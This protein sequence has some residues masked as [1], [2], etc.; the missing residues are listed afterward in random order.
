MK[1]SVRTEDLTRIFKGEEGDI[2]A[3]DNVSLSVLP[4]EIFGLLGPNGAGKTTLI[5]ILSTLL[6]PTSGKAFVDG[7][8]VVRETQ[9][10]KEVINLASGGETPG[11]GMLTVKENLWFF[12]QLYGLSNELSKTRIEQLTETV[13]LN[14]KINERM[15]RLSSGMKQRLNIARCL[16]NDPKILFLDEPT[17]GLDVMVA[18]EIRQYIEKLVKERPDKTILLTTHYMAEADQMCNRVA[19]IDRGRVLVVG[20]P[21]KLKA[22]FSKEVNLLVQTSFIGNKADQL[23]KVKG[24]K[25]LSTSHSPETNMTTLKLVLEEEGAVPDVMSTLKEMNAKLHFMQKAETTLETVF[26]SLVGRG[27]E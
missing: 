7:H 24:V 21:E 6:L 16:I 22:I 20:A 12:S 4:G 1:E 25:G 18:Q 19:I 8:D 14:E 3:L 10:V 2:K 5:K 17:L 13:G 23:L 26:M 27:L 9:K 15:N 11:Y